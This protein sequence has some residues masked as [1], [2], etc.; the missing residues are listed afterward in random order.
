M[1]DDLCKCLRLFT[2]RSVTNRS[3]GFS[4]VEF[5]HE[6]KRAKKSESETVKERRKLLKMN[7][8]QEDNFVRSFE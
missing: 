4:R 7:R 6:K 5:L 1:Y 3:C 8:M 2:V